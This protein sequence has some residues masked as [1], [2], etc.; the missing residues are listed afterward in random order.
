M[1]EESDIWKKGSDGGKG[2]TGGGR[3]EGRKGRETK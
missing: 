2:R 3:K 1:I